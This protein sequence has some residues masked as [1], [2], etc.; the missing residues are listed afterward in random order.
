M[1]DPDRFTD[2]T[3][4]S[5]DDA[6]ERT[7]HEPRPRADAELKGDLHTMRASELAAEDYA[8]AWGS[9]IEGGTVFGPAIVSALLAI[10]ERLESLHGDLVRIEQRLAEH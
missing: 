6:L 3:N 9:E 5:V 7:N 2:L 8:D 4:Q 10:S 1:T